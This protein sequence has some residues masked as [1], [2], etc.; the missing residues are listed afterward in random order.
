[1]A[2]KRTFTT[3]V[4]EVNHPA[5]TATTTIRLEHSMA[6]T[7][8]YSMTQSSAKLSPELKA[9]YESHNVHGVEELF[10][11]V[12]NRRVRFIRLNPRHDKAET[13]GLLEVSLSDKCSLRTSLQVYHI[14]Q[15]C[16]DHSLAFV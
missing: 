1:M 12:E 4:D 16:Y 14:T 6:A 3:N 15:T 2:E 9:F 10:G 5:Q 13:L 7:E 11:E 8:S